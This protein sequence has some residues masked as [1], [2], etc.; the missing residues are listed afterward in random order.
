M[1]MMVSLD[2]LKRAT[3]PM[4]ATILNTAA[5]L[6]IEAKIMVDM[7]KLCMYCLARAK[8]DCN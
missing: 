2:V 8:I 1:T 7:I 4:E 6:V 3:P 5:R